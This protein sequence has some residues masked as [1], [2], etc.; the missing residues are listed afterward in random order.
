VLASLPILFGSLFLPWFDWTS[1]VD[2]SWDDPLLAIALAEIVLVLVVL[3]ISAG[4]LLLHR[5]QVVAIG[6]AGGAGMNA[7]WLGVFVIS[8]ADGVKIGAWILTIVGATL[9]AAA[10]LWLWQERAGQPMHT[11]RRA[12]ALVGALVVVTAEIIGSIGQSPKLVVPLGLSV[13]GVAAIFL[14][15]RRIPE[16]F[17]VAA[18]SAF[19]AAGIISTGAAINYL[20]RFQDHGAELTDF[21]GRVALDGVIAAAMWIALSRP[22]GTSGRE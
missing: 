12:R 6:L 3:A 16:S 9:G 19:T 10:G 18:L 13:V 8:N 5:S 22:F 14:V 1:A 11:N 20:S 4:C 15:P 17:R 21:S 7:F 2:L